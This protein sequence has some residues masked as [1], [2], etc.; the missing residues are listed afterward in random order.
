MLLINIK[1]FLKGLSAKVRGCSRACGALVE[2]RVTK[3]KDAA[4]V[5]EGE[6]EERGMDESCL[7]FK[8]D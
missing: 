4:T 7:H 6:K 2:M 1:S 8:V 5:G 3:E